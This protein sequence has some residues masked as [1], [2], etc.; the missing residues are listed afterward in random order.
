M[1][2][3]VTEYGEQLR[4]AGWRR[5][6]ARRHL[7]RFAGGWPT[8]RVAVALV[9]LLVAAPAVAATQA[10]RPLLGDGSARAPKATDAPAA[11]SQ[12]AL[13]SVLRRPQRAADRGAQTTY[14]LK[15]LG[16]SV[17]NVRT[18]EIRLLH[19]EPDGRGIVL[20]PVGRYGLAPAGLPAAMRRHWHRPAGRDGLCLFAAD[21]DHGKPAGGG[22]GCY[23]TRQLLDGQATAGLG[24]RVY[25]LVP[26]GVDRIAVTL[27]GRATLMVNVAQNFFIYGGS[28]G[29]GTIRWLDHDGKVLRTLRRASLR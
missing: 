20:I 9:A 14:A 26:D 25:G 12:R 2:D 13:L 23:G 8:R 15:F 28:L 16:S 17:A 10:W 21:Q 24:H 22:F 18:T 27:A 1:S 19:V 5:L 3:F 11:A 29:R 4:Q 7:P 6:H